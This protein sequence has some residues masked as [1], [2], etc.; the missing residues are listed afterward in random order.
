MFCSV[1][2]TIKKTKENVVNFGCFAPNKEDLKGRFILI[3]RT[4][5]T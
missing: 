5:C 3:E 2:N 1:V 4:C